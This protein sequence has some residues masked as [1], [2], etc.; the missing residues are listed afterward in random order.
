MLSNTKIA[1]KNQ[2][3]FFVQSEFFI[4]FQSILY[5]AYQVR[6]EKEMKSF[7][8]NLSPSKINIIRCQLALMNFSSIFGFV[9]SVTFDFH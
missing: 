5:E 6:K 9:S 1:L 8:M 7:W 4:F 3:N 2:C